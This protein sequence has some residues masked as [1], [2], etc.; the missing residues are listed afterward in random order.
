MVT[1]PNHKDKF[2][3]ASILS[4]LEKSLLVIQLADI[5]IIQ[6]RI[7]RIKPIQ[8]VVAVSHHQKA[9][10]NLEELK[11]SLMPKTSTSSSLTTKVTSGL[12]QTCPSTA[13]SASTS[14]CSLKSSASS[15]MAAS[16]STEMV[17][18]Q[19]QTNRLL[20]QVTTNIEM[21][22][23]IFIHSFRMST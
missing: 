14:S 11:K 20:L 5:L 13:E 19:T 4:K 23:K 12:N 7:R 17:C 22:F 10:T 15:S 1:F 2:S 8:K 18:P 9:K 6:I 16:P 3:P 21:L